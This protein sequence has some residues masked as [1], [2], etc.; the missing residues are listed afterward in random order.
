[1]AKIG[2]IKLKLDVQGAKANVDVTYEIQ[3][4]KKDIETKQVYAEECRL[5]GDDTHAGD[6]A[7]DPGPMSPGDDTIGFLTPLFNKNTKADGNQS[8]ERHLT[9]KF[10][11]ADLNE[12]RGSMPNPDEL[13]ARVTLTPVKP[14]TGNPVKR[15]SRMVKVKL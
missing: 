12:D 7:T 14:T 11:T 4:S 1:M 3:F 13:R 8:I 10:R 6:P 15:E 9:K 5:I 2:S